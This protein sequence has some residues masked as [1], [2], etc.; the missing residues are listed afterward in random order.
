MFKKKETS[1]IKIF[2]R[3]ENNGESKEYWKWM[4]L[5]VLEA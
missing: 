2:R 3:V 1:I 4:A 5:R